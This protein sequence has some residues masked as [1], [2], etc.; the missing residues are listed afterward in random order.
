[1]IPEVDYDYDWEDEVEDDYEEETYP[2]RTYKMDIGNK[3][4]SG[5][6]DDEEALRQA[7]YKILNT[8]LGED[9]IYEDDYGLE[10]QDLFG[11][12]LIYAESEIQ[13][14][15]RE[16]ILSD[17][18]FSAVDNFEVSTKEGKMLVSFVVY[19]ADGEEISVDEGVELDV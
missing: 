17:D 4:I 15:I 1:M 16:A 2:N 8:E 9:I 19:T 6:C 10:K 13:V 18:R 3:R 5:M 14:R 12:D 11:D 7:V